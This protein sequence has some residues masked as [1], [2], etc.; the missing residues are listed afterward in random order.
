MQINETLDWD[1]A[2]KVAGNNPKTA[3]ELFTFFMKSFPKE[4]NAIQKAF[5]CQEYKKLKA[6]IHTLH[7]ALCY[8]GLPR[9]KSATMQLEN[10][11]KKMELI[12]V[13]ELFLKFEQEAQ[14]VLLL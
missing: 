3:K 2:V 9:L 13:P 5:E 6:L 11:L 7:G 10:A 1:L 12:K 4:L 14:A 8:C